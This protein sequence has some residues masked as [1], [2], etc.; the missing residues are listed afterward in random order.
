[1]LLQKKHKITK[2]HKI[3][4]PERPGVYIFW[5]NE[6]KPLYIGKSLNLKNRVTSYFLTNTTGKTRQMVKKALFVSWIIVGNEVESLLL[7][8]NLVKKYQPKY[9]VSLK[10]DKNPLYIRITKEEYPRILTARK[11]ELKEKTQVFFGPFPSST[12]VYFVLSM[13]RKIFPYSTHKMGKMACLYSQIGLCNPC[14]NEIANIK[15]VNLKEKQKLIYLS[16]IKNI[17]GIL[18][19]RFKRVRQALDK[20]MIIYSDNEDFEIA[21]D[22]KDRMEKLD[23][24][25]QE[26]VNIKEFLK[27]PNLI[28]DIRQEEIKNLKETINQFYPLKKLDRIECFDVAHISGFHTTASMVT[29]IDGEP[30]KKYYR[31]FRI[32]KSKKSDDTASLSEIAKRR[33]KHF[34]DWGEPDLIIVDGGKGQVSAFSLSL[35]ANI[36]VVG[37][38]KREETLIYIKNSKGK[39]IFIQQKMPSG[40]ARNLVQRI[41][42]EAHRFARRYHH[43]LLKRELLS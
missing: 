6:N 7:E 18:S 21:L 11:N 40:P 31:H 3:K 41:R 36:P 23:Y 26:R 14:P 15:D 10:D 27:N 37:L 42:N 34:D 28:D 4:I 24:I 32:K 35:I 13:L 38:A 8:A 39:Q 33:S 22:I 30:E 20:E 16:N 19:G 5:E 43:H 25:T 17:K 12:N 1:M 29:F 9:N 2:T